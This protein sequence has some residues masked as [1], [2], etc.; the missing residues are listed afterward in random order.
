MPIGKG[1]GRILSPSHFLMCFNN[2]AASL[3]RQFLNKEKHVK[4]NWKT[5]KYVFRFIFFT[6]ESITHNELLPWSI[7]TDK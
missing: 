5:L 3:T 4:K 7:C 1:K 6:C 2:K